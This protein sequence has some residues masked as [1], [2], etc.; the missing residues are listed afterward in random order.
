MTSR[1]K[2]SKLAKDYGECRSGIL[3]FFCCHFYWKNNIFCIFIDDEDAQI[4]EIIGS[5]RESDEDFNVSSVESSDSEG[6]NDE[7]KCQFCNGK[8]FPSEN[9]LNKHQWFFH[10]AQLK[11]KKTK[12]KKKKLK[13]LTKN[14]TEN[15]DEQTIDVVQV[16]LTQN[17]N[18]A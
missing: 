17:F 5:D 7:F 14:A 11:S 12:N 6:D 13:K 16:I 1:P 15:N 10:E 2:R 8:D 3:I 18:K 9:L 4:R